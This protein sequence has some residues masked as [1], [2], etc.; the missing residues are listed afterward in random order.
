[1]FYPIYRFLV[2]QDCL[3]LPLIF[4]LWP[5]RD[6]IKEPYCNGNYFYRKRKFFRELEENTSWVRIRNPP[7]E[8]RQDKTN[9]RM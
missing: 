3:D 6:T 2:G 5:L 4:C 9:I 1:V 8:K 7:K